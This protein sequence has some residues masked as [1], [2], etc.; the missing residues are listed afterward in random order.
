MHLRAT[1][2]QGG[3]VAHKK[4]FIANALL[5]LYPH[6]VAVQVGGQ[7]WGVWHPVRGCAFVGMA[8]EAPSVVLPALCELALA[9]AKQRQVVVRVHMV[10]LQRQGGKQGGF[11]RSGLAALGQAAAQ[12]VVQAHRLRVPLGGGLQK[13]HGLFGQARLFVEHAQVV[14][15]FLMA[16]VQHEGLDELH[17]RGGGLPGEL[18]GAAQGQR[19]FDGQGLVVARVQVLQQG[20][21]VGITA[22]VEQ[23]FASQKTPVHLLGLRFQR[24]GIS[25]QRPCKFP[26]GQKLVTGQ[27]VVQARRGLSHGVVVSSRPA[28]VRGAIRQPWGRRRIRGSRGCPASSAA[29]WRRGWG[30]APV[31]ASSIRVVA[32][33]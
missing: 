16:G 6:G 22:Q 21:T 3:Q 11:G 26:V 12:V 30:P 8:V 19:M 15:R 13:G 27:C 28:G 9:Q 31:A 33:L 20:H 18:Q 14:G 2:L 10:G 29:V 24:L 23:R 25:V 7:L 4:Q 32:R 1:R 5:P 17:L